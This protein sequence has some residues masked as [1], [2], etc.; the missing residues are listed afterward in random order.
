VLTPE[1][2]ARLMASEPVRVRALRI[3][4]RG[5][6]AGLP[7]PDMAALR[8]SIDSCLSPASDR[9]IEVEA[10]A[11]ASYADLLQTLAICRDAGAGTLVLGDREGRLVAQAYRAR[12]GASPAAADG[13]AFDQPPRIAHTEKPVYPAAARQAGVAGA[14]LV[15]VWIDEEGRCIAARPLAPNV[16]AELIDAALAAA[17]KWRFEPARREGMAVVS[18]MV[19]PFEFRARSQP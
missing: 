2:G 3:P 6:D 9:I 12:Y 19:I 7:F 13:P 16:A 8:A 1:R 17:L 18:S 4:A 11:E 10:D 15:S 14:V 5:R